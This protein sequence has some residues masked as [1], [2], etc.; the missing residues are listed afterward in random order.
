LSFAVRNNYENGT[1]Y[2][3]MLLF[4]TKASLSQILNPTRNRNHASL[5]FLIS[6]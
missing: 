5:A 3:P 4:K 2:K 6:S 1:I